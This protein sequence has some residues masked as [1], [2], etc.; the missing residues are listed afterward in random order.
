MAIVFAGLVGSPRAAVPCSAIV[1]TPTTWVRD[2]D[3]I[4]RV[5]AV[6]E[7]G[8]RVRGTLEERRERYAA[9][10][11]QYGTSVKF[12]VL[13]TLKGQAPLGA[14]ELEGELTVGDD[15]NNRPVPYDFVRK[16]GRSGNCY[17]FQYKQGAEYLLICRIRNGLLTPHW[18]PMAATNE[19]LTGPD[20]DWLGWVRQQLASSRQ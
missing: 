15:F 17:A 4:V 9:T 6:Q 7:L 2:S 12:V 13:E 10:G 16:A 18:A 1:G 20:D 3:V 11:R 14:I 5:R 8:S 19:Q